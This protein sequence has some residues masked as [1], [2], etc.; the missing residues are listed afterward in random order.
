MFNIV[1]TDSQFRRITNIKF[2]SFPKKNV[3]TFNTFKLR[4]YKMYPTYL[5]FF[6]IELSDGH[7][8]NL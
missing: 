4:E 5:F 3:L 6:Q 7:N 8:T 2:I 1:R